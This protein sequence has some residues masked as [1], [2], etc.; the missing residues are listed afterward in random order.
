MEI[1]INN[2]KIDFSLETETVLHEVIDGINSWAG[3]DGF[4]IKNIYYDDLQYDG[5]K[6]NCRNTP[7]SEIS[8]LNITALSR[9]EVHQENLQLLHQYISLF[10]KSIEGVNIT[11]IRELQL[12]S[13]SLCN[14]LADFLE[15]VRG[16]EDT[17]SGKLHSNIMDILTEDSG[18]KKETEIILMQQLSGLKIILTERISELSNPLGELGKTVTAMKSSVEEINDISV[19]LQTGKDR[20][21]LNCIIKFS[22]LSQKIL[23]LYPVL[24]GS[25]I[26]NFDN[27]RINDLVFSDFYIDLNNI[28]AE[29]IEA[30]T[31]NDSVLIGDLL[32]YEV[33]P[34]M[35]SLINTLDDLSR[36]VNND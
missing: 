14:L 9:M 10:I 17:I 30:F 28:L 35:N 20:E 31:A 16:A 18:I 7:L 6:D 23:R 19:L 12:E 24:T 13:E 32:E 33:A 36:S 2:E 27:I 34:R 11:L 8:S 4:Q 5:Q 1:F 26:I 25:G 29:L 3:K 22:E 15:E 21:A